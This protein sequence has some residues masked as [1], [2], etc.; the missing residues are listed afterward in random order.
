MGVPKPELPVVEALTLRPS[1][2]A[3][4]QKVREEIQALRAVAVLLVLVYH[5]W[6]GV[7]RGGYIG[8]DVFFVISGFLITAHLVRDIDRHGSVR[9]FRFWARRARRLLPAS[10]LVLVITAVAVLIVVPRSLW[11]QFLVEVG[12]SALYVQN[13]LLAFNSVDYLAA[14]NVP[15]PVQH[16]W[17]LS[18]EEQFY[19]GL[20]LVMLVVLLVTRRRS[21][22]ARRIGIII[23]LSLVSLASLAYGAFLTTADPGP[24]Y[25]ATTAR[26]WEFAAGGILALVAVAP[27]AGRVALRAM[28]SWLGLALIAYAGFVYTGATPFPGVAAIVPTVG[29][30][31]VIWAGMSRVWWAPTRIFGLRPVQYLGDISYSLYLWHWPLLILAG[32]A[33]T[34]GLN[35]PIKIAIVAAAVVLSALT[36]SFVEDP[37]RQNRFLVTRAPRWTFGLT[38][39]AM[40]VVLFAS[41]AGWANVQRDLDRSLQLAATL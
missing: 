8:V 13:W 16:F 12:A 15:S 36:K 27:P 40:A 7:S 20:P 21:S 31:M 19:I 34:S 30:I 2:P 33:F 24:A 18:V 11:Q 26:A 14:S 38:A 17:T 25:F 41:G 32:Y 39:A 29:T 35:L 9:P 28:V 5:F 3:Q 1:S 22:R 6:P 23:A 4:R 37:V 10:L